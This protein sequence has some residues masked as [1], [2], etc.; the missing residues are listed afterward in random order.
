MLSTTDFTKGLKPDDVMGVRKFLDAYMRINASSKGIAFPTTKASEKD[1]VKNPE[2]YKK[3]NRN[4]WTPSRNSLSPIP[5]AWKEWR[6][7][8]RTSTRPTHGTNW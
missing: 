7:N 8:W 2:K 3:L 4:I 1:K 5:A 6:T